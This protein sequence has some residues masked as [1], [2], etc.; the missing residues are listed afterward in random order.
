[1]KFERRYEGPGAEAQALADAREWL[2][3]K[4]VATLRGYVGQPG[5]MDLRDLRIVC[6]LLG[7]SGRP[8]EALGRDLGLR[9]PPADSSDEEY[10]L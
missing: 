5:L 1:M 3:E 8:V 2:G 10:P 7:L 6:S 9:E 4:K